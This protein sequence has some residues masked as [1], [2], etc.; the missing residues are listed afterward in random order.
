MFDYLKMANRV[1]ILLLILLISCAYGQ[2]SDN[3][4]LEQEKQTAQMAVSEITEYIHI[5]IAKKGF[6]FEVTKECHDLNQFHV[7]VMAE[8]MVRYGWDVDNYRLTAMLTS[9]KRLLFKLIFPS[10]INSDL[11]YG[12]TWE[13]VQKA[14]PRKDKSLHVESTG[15]LTNS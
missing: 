6:C 8:I 7:D 12:A 15:I 4:E 13:I 3:K 2:P 14:I 10:Y 5:V 1:L 9:D 11:M